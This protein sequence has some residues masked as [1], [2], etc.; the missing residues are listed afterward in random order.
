MRATVSGETLSMCKGVFSR[1][2][3]AL[4]FSVKRI[5]VG[6]I[7]RLEKTQLEMFPDKMSPI[8]NFHVND[9]ICTLLTQP[10]GE[11]VS[12]KSK[13]SIQSISKVQ[14]RPQALII[15]DKTF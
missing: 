1:I 13:I 15:F 4:L 9:F 11:E 14:K 2:C 3:V 5:V 10:Q 12:P 6:T 7:F 8:R